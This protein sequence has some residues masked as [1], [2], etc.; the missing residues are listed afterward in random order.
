[1]IQNN[2]INKNAFTMNILYVATFT[3]SFLILGNLIST[4]SS[5]YS[6]SLNTFTQLA[7][8]SI[9]STNTTTNSTITTNANYTELEQNTKA[10]LLDMKAKNNPPINS[11]PPNEARAALYGLQSSY[12][13]TIPEVSA[14]EHLTIPVGSNNETIAI[15]IV[16]PVGIDSSQQPTPVVMYFHGGGWV[17]G[18]FDTH[19]R[20]IKELANAANVTVVYVNYTLS[21][22]AKFPQALE[23]AY[24]A[25]KWVADNGQS[26]NVNS[27]KLGVAGDSAGGNM[28]TAVTM[29]AKERD[30]P[31]ISLQALFYPVTDVNFNTT[32]YEKFQ[33]GYHLTRD[34][35]IWFWNNYLDNQTTNIKDPLVSPLQASISQLQGLPPALVITDENDVLRDEGEAYAHK[36]MEAGVPVASVRYLG[37]IHDFMML[38]ALANTPAVEEAISQAA[39]I[40]NK[41]L[42]S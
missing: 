10:F 4:P 7:Y 23:E 35:M 14:V 18:G 19:E 5:I 40:I 39:S 9:N 29:L 27:T 22:E 33:K 28:A 42:Y 12:P 30:Y 31:F 36:L 8:G 26:I 25:T 3:I 6:S 32:S 21:P 11:L 41:V 16:R 17:L 38:N 15:Q 37:T 24:A 20:L 34:A 1:M 2:N 13:A